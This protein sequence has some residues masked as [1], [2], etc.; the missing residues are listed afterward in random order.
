L[1]FIES[2]FCVSTFCPWFNAWL[3]GVAK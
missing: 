1:A 3:F 2:K